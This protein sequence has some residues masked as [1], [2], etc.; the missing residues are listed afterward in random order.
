MVYL[1][2]GEFS[3]D[4]Q[5]RE[6]QINIAYDE[7]QQSKM[8]VVFLLIFVAEAKIIF[9]YNFIAPLTKASMDI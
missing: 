5:R 4:F 7:K 9:G 3:K 6:D 1:G 2:L 8:L